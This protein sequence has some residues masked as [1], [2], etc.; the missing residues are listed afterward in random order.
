MDLILVVILISII[1][2]IKVNKYNESLEN[3]LVMADDGTIVSSTDELP[4]GN[5]VFLNYEPH[6]F[7]LIIRELGLRK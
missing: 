6:A 1:G 3:E 4:V 5:N 2:F 7:E